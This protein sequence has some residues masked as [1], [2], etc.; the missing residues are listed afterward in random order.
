[1]ITNHS[2]PSDKTQPSEVECKTTKEVTPTITQAYL[3]FGSDLG[4]DRL[5][6]FTG[7]VFGPGFLVVRVGLHFVFVAIDITS[8][9]LLAAYRFCIQ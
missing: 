2:I 1:M 9:R 5:C 4:L 7:T 6:S 3:Y 8:L